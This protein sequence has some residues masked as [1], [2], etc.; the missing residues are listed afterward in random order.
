[1]EPV[2][3]VVVGIDGSEASLDALCWALKYASLS[4]AQVMAVI[5]WQ[6]PNQYGVECYGEQPDWRQIT[7]DILHAAVAEVASRLGDLP[8]VEQL[9]RQGHPAEVL[10]EAADG[11]DL[12][13]VGSHGHG[14]FVGMLMGSVSKH[15]TAHA[16]CP[17]VV[18]PPTSRNAGN[19]GHRKSRQNSLGKDRRADARS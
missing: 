1:M 18:V 16:C 7:S 6:Y 2:G 19:S 14:G 3:R 17:V 4:S 9:V 13:V 15:V 10:L 8:P 5:S 11:A 12:L